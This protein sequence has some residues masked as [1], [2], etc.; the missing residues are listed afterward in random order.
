MLKRL[1]NWLFPRPQLAAAGMP[2]GAFAELCGPGNGIFGRDRSTLERLRDLLLAPLLAI[3]QAVTDSFKKEL[4]EARHNFLT[5]GGNNFKIALYDSTATL[6]NATTAYAAANE[7]VGANYTAGGMALTR[8]NPTNTGNVAFTD[9]ADVNWP[10]STITARGALIY[11]V[12]QSN[13]SVL[14]LDFGSDKTS[15]AGNF[16]VVF[17]TAN[18]SAAILRIGP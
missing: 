3:S 5:S 7:V 12:D 4:L 8:V 16:T 15:T 6:G 9:F 17:P 11:N 1:L 2:F 18:A 10:V 14:V 13:A